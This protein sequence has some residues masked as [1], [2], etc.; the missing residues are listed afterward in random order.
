MNKMKSN[1]S[2]QGIKNI[3]VLLLIL[4]LTIYFSFLLGIKK[5]MAI[6]SS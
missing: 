3:A 5:N 1:Y 4:L 6:L 2:W